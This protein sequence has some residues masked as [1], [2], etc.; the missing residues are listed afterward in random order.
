[1]FNTFIGKY[2]LH[3]VPRNLVSLIF[4]REFIHED[5]QMF[6]KYFQ[7]NTSRI[8]LKKHP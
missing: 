5:I 2:I 6:S 3:S 1:M 7:H 8:I 4:S